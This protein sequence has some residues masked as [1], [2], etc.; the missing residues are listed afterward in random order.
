M[1]WKRKKRSTDDSCADSDPG[2]SL[3][4]LVPILR[5]EIRVNEMT[6][7]KLMVINMKLLREIETLRAERGKKDAD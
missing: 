2:V 7:R 3:E 5:D 6:I 4:K 1:L